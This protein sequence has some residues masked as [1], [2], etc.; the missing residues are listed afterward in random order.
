MKNIHVKC[1]ITVSILHCT[2]ALKSAL[3]PYPFH[4]NVYCTK[5]HVQFLDSPKQYEV[6]HVT[7][8]GYLSMVASETEHD[9]V[10]GDFCM[11]F[12]GCGLQEDVLKTWLRA[13]TRQV[14]LFGMNSRF[15]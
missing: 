5:G 4:G 1:I 9:T 7:K 12:T 10:D 15:F 2:V 14:H 6:I 8:S 13:C 3:S 11:V